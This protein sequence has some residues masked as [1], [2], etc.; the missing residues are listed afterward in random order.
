MNI[1]YVNVKM[2]CWQVFCN[3]LYKITEHNDMKFQTHLS[4][5]VSHNFYTILFCYIST[6]DAFIIKIGIKKYVIRP[7]IE[8]GTF[9][10]LSRC[11]DQLDHRTNLL[12]CKESSLVMTYSI[13]C[14]RYKCY[15]LKPMVVPSAVKRHKY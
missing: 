1:D 5:S 7:R 2:G 9:C 6:I 14:Y 3:I 8:L 10:V 15:T 12:F 4:L 13:P 11:H